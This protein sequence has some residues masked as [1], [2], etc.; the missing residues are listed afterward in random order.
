M[1]LGRSVE[2]LLLWAY[3]ESKEVRTVEVFKGFPQGVRAKNLVE[4]E[5]VWQISGGIDLLVT[6]DST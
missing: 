5:L 2:G 3:A 1:E 6:E 4:V